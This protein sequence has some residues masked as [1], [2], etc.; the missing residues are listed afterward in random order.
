MEYYQTEKIPDG[1]YPK[2]QEKWNWWTSNH[3]YNYILNH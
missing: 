3:N 1:I 2:T